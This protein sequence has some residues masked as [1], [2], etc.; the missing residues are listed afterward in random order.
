MLVANR[1]QMSLLWRKHQ[2]WRRWGFYLSFL[3]EALDILFTLFHFIHWSITLMKKKRNTYSRYPLV[4]LLLFKK[5]RKNSL[6]HLMNGCSNFF[7]NLESFLMIVIIAKNLSLPSSKCFSIAFNSIFS[8][9]VAN[10]NA[11]LWIFDGLQGWGSFS[12]SSPPTKFTTCF[13]LLG[14]IFSSI[15]VLLKSSNLLFM[16]NSDFSF[17]NSFLGRPLFGFGSALLDTVFLFGFWRVG[18]WTNNSVVLWFGGIVGGCG[19]AES[20]R[21]LNCWKNCWFHI[22]NQGQ[23]LI[24]EN[25]I[26][27]VFIKRNQPQLSFGWASAVFSWPS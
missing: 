16:V 12:V 3:V 20:K 22:A 19:I 25:S 26:W 8:S 4:L 27:L 24:A 17:P 11:E 14:E 18:G 10:W 15:S 2:I 13:I 5:T 23:Q 1:R 7:I 6:M 21:G 9:F